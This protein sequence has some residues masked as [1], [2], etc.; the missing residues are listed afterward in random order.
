MTW[1]FGVSTNEMAAG[2][3][4]AAVPGKIQLIGDEPQPRVMQSLA[5]VTQSYESKIE[6]AAR[7]A[8]IK[9]R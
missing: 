5:D 4:P 7:K 6:T 9:R 3:I 1:Q 8:K 2:N